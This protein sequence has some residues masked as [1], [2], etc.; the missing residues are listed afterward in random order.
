MARVVL[1]LWR[2]SAALASVGISPNR[3]TTATSTYAARLT[4]QITLLAVEEAHGALRRRLHVL[5]KLAKGRHL[6]RVELQRGLAR[7][8]ARIPATAVGGSVVIVVVVLRLCRWSLLKGALARRRHLARTE[9]S[10]R[11]GGHESAAKHAQKGWREG[12]ASFSRGTSQF[13]LPS[14]D[15]ASAL[16]RRILRIWRFIRDPPLFSRSLRDLGRK[17]ERKLKKESIYYYYLEGE[18]K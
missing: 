1:A 8:L 14:L 3:P 18:L 7:R 11:G 17:D 6:A 10:R 5:E 15:F 12:G 2:D 13:R 16:A 9:G 4:Q